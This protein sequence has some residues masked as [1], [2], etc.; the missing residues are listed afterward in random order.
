[1]K[2]TIIELRTVL[3]L[4]GVHS[5]LI[6]SAIHNSGSF[7][8]HVEV[9]RTP[10]GGI[11]P[12]TV[13]DGDDTL[14][15]IYFKGDASGGDIEY[16]YRGPN[17]TEFSK[18]IRVNTVPGSAVAIGTVRG[19]QMALGR[20]GRVYV[21]W[22]GAQLKSD[23]ST[24][25]MPVFFAR[26]N[27]SHTAFETQRDVMQYAKGGDGGLSV[28]ADMRGNVYAVWHA[29]GGEPG[30][31]HRVVYMAHSADDGKHFD[32][33]IPISPPELG[34]CGCCGMRALADKSGTFYVFYRAAAKSVHRD[35][36]LLV[37]SDQGRTFR[38]I[39]VAPWELNACPMSTAYLSEAG[40]GI[41]AAWERAGQVYFERIDRDSFTSSQPVEAPA[42]GKNRKH[43]AIA[44]NA[45]DQTLFVWT[46]G[47]AWA[48]GGSLAW[49]LFD[50]DGKPLGA[51]GYSLDVPVWDR[52]SVLSDRLGNFT[53]M[54]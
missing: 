13:L 52:P 36:T 49:Q 29:T 11:Q 31:D 30:E 15:V 53:V 48:K 46:E 35:M 9:L 6:A 8:P 40:R 39:A 14:H 54:Y 24:A 4:L 44:A 51:T 10:N 28:A 37:S 5:A 27:D 38:T 19:P 12:Q 18:P 33:E 16:V 7:A 23:D 34:A 50:K 43:P 47:T 3:T 1:M 42:E 25:T 41:F 2:R 20:D 26:L 21:I 45:S 17:R 22:F 32:R